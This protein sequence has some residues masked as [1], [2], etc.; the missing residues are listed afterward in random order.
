M[1]VVSKWQNITEPQKFPIIPSYESYYF[2]GSHLPYMNFNSKDF[3]G[4]VIYLEKTFLTLY[5]MFN[6]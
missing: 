3:M 2:L 5:F 1:G 6:L 4:H